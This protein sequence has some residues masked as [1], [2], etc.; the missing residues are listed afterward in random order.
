MRD[1]EVA[2]RSIGLQ[3]KVLNAST[4]GE[5]NAAF[6]TLTREQPDALFVGGD[7]NSGAL[8]MLALDGAY[9]LGGVLGENT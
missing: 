5:I 7:E 8:A 2:A 3:L 4:S 9:L 1:V 6:V